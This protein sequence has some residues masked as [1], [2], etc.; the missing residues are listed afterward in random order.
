MRAPRA[1]RYQKPIANFHGGREIGLLSRAPV[2]RLQ[3][4]PDMSKGAAWPFEIPVRLKQA[5]LGEAVSDQ[6]F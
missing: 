1:E 4:A 2:S 6:G 5:T 3:S